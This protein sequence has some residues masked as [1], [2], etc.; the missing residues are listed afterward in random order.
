MPG[1]GSKNVHFLPSEADGRYFLEFFFICNFHAV[2]KKNQDRVMIS[3]N[4]FYSRNVAMGTEN[5]SCVTL[6]LTSCFHLVA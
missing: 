5:F 3:A 1:R 6:P 2:E 4:L